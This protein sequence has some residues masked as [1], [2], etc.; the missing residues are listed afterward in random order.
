MNKKHLLALAAVLVGASQAFAVTDI[1]VSPK[2]SDENDGSQAKPYQTVD[3]AVLC[4]L[5]NEE[6]VIHLEKDA[7]FTIGG[8]L[9]VGENKQL[10]I[11]GDNSTILGAAKPGTEG[12]A[13]R[14]LA[15][16]ANTNLKLYGINFANGRQVGYW[17]G[18]AVFFDG[19]E[20]TIDH[21]TFKDN[22]AGSG[23]GAIAS[24]GHIVRVSNSYFEGNYIIG[25]GAR[26]GAIMQ[27]G[28]EV[29]GESK[30]ELYVDNCTFYKNQLQQGGQGT[31]ID[32]YENSD[33]QKMSCNKKLVITNS[34]FVDNKSI[35]PYQA[36]IDISGYEECE[37][38]LI[39]N[40]FYG[41]DGVIRLFFQ[42]AP[43]YMF[44][45]FAFVNKATVL[46][47]NG[48]SIADTDRTAIVAKNNILYGAERGVNEYIDD[49]DLTTGAA[50]AHNTIGL[51]KDASMV[52]L[53]VSTELGTRDQ[54]FV[55]FLPI[56]RANSPLVGAGIANSA[57]WTTENLIP[58]IDCRGYLREGAVSVG[59]YQYDGKVA[60]V[61]DIYVEPDYSNAPVE[62]F[63]L[64]GIR[65][66]NPENGIFIR[67]Q[68]NKATKVR[69]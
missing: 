62:Y 6:T 51:C 42:Q 43:L 47:E 22:E 31:A 50:A 48:G 2:G 13:P 1:Y 26:G 12:Q 66:A 7:T 11:I 53:G 41:G 33:G 38:A 9:N 29:E 52:V 55:P 14:I 32:I 67:R 18:G 25:G 58:T 35:D 57:E 19:E 63:N 28:N 17:G 45:N 44:N 16:R 69:L 8:T 37:T 65:V 24:R 34:T 46:S 20:L 54:G 23:G 30:G 56:I 49:P 59:A 21:C 27:R 36:A 5:E 10:S 64:Q 61:E 68:G 3:M 4:V 60:G 39:N 40:T 15:A